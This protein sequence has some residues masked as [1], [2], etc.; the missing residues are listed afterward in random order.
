MAAT[1]WQPSQ[2]ERG[3]AGWPTHSSTSPVTVIGVGKYERYL[4]GRLS[5][6]GPFSSLLQS[7]VAWLQEAQMTSIETDFL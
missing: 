3:R 2:G 5:H 4:L 1:Y 6:L 7:K